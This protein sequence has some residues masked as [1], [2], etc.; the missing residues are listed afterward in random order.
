MVLF[1]S[2]VCIVD[3]QSCVHAI[4]SGIAARKQEGDVCL[5]ECYVWVCCVCVCGEQYVGMV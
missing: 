1:K 5:F 4:R 3:G 2:A